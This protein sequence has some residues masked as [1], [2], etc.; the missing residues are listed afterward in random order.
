[1]QEVLSNEV[2]C[3][4]QVNVTRRTKMTSGDPLFSLVSGHISFLPFFYHRSICLPPL[5]AP[6]LC[7]W[8]IVWVPV[9]GSPFPVHSCSFPT[10]LTSGFSLASR[11]HSH[12][13]A[14]WHQQEFLVT[15]AI[16]DN[17]ASSPGRRK[18]R[19]VGIGQITDRRENLTVQNQAQDYHRSSGIH[20]TSSHSNT[21]QERGIMRNL[22]KGTEV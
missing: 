20:S 16:M 2:L 22:S 13:S 11:T 7:S 21:F 5:P 6:G 17:M 1:M 19:Y 8:A 18:W 4:S 14:S 15:W 10:S 12:L 3:F 9:S